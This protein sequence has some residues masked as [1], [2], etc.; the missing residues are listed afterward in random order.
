MGLASTRPEDA[1]LLEPSSTD[2]TLLCVAELLTEFTLSKF[3]A[4]SLKSALMASID[5]PFSVDCAVADGGVPSDGSRGR[6]TRA[7]R[8]AVGEAIEVDR[9]VAAHSGCGAAAPRRR[10][11]PL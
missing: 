4:V 1:D 8:A 10:Y 2:Y 11:E 9:D 7:V 6:N 5:E 3:K